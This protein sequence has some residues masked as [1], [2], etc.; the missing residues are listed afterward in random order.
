MQVLGKINNENTSLSPYVLVF[1]AHRVF[2]VTI[3]LLNLLLLTKPFRDKQ[4]PPPFDR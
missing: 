2:R 3:L 1:S 4:C